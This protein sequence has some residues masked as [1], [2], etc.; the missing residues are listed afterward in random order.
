MAMQQDADNVM[1]IIS[2]GAIPT[3]LFYLATM[4]LLLENKTVAHILQP[5]ARVGQMAFTNYVSICSSVM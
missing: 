1:L 5:V 4:F 2:L 3:M